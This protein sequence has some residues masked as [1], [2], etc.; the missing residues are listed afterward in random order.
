MTPDQP[1]VRALA[2]RLVSSGFIAGEILAYEDE[3]GIV[4]TMDFADAKALARALLA[5]LGE[6]D[7]WIA[8]AKEAYDFIGRNDEPTVETLLACWRRR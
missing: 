5:A 2:L 3:H 1:D 6:R 7:A 4:R 8:R